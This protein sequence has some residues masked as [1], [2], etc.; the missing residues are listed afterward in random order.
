MS[1]G[2]PCAFWITAKRQAEIKDSPLAAIE[3]HITVTTLYTGIS[4]GTERL[5][6][7]GKVPQSEFETMRA[8][9]KDGSFAFPVK[10]GY[11]AVGQ[12]QESDRAGQTVFALF[13]HQT[14]FTIPGEAT[15]PVPDDVPAS[16]AILAANME[17][18]LNI[19]WDASVSP[20]DR[21]AVI[22]A[23]VVGALTAYLCARI[24]GTDVCLIDIDP[25]KSAL[26]E[27][28]G[29]N[30]SLPDTAPAENDVILHASATSAGLSTAIALAGTEA[31]IV[32]ASW[33]GTQQ[34]T[35]PL[36]G[37]F[38]QKRLRI[39]SSQVGRIPANHAVRWTYRRRLTKAL[40][41][42]ADPVLDVLI[43][44]ESPFDSLPADYAQ[45]LADPGTLC[46]RISYPT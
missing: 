23:G 36:G 21:V 19:L 11:S 7:E 28:F 10:Y 18:A 5:V 45:I 25:T 31:T 30:F 39:V 9:F 16:R 41:L 34:T 24:P 1:R 14:Q 12:V 2:D 20:G 37:A 33:Y 29:C 40:A 46:H 4:R 8:P 27:A 6:F 22:G 42:L 13:P 17:T 3:G 15:I 43:S 35:V 32:E 26:A 38:H 44:G